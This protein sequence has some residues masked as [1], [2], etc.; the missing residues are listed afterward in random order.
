MEKRLEEIFW[1]EGK[2]VDGKGS[3]VKSEFIGPSICVNYELI[4]P[5][6]E[7]KPIR[8]FESELTRRLNCLKNESSIYK[9]ANAYLMGDEIN[10]PK[11]RDHFYDRKYTL[12]LVK[13]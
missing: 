13:I 8:K 6:L 11:M 10:V 4:T 5:S 9:E 12:N 3:E 1:K 7:S 2:F